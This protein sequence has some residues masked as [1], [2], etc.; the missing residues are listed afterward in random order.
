M[1]LIIGMNEKYSLADGRVFYCPNGQCDQMNSY[2]TVF[3][4]NAYF[5]VLQ[6]VS[7]ESR[8][9]DSPWLLCQ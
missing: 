4:R 5:D 2:Y 9:D 7:F 8:K 6:I 3:G 1:V